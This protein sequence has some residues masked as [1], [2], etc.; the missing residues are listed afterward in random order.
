MLVFDLHAEGGKV[1]LPRSRVPYPV[2]LAYHHI[3]LAAFLATENH[4]STACME[5]VCDVASFLV[6]LKQTETNA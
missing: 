4:D 3:H 5:Q 2:C 6:E 1:C